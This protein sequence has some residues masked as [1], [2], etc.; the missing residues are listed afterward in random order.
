[1]YTHFL[2]KKSHQFC[3]EYSI[4]NISMICRFLCSQINR[5]FNF[6]IEELS[7]YLSIYIYLLSYCNFVVCTYLYNFVYFAVCKTNNDLLG[8][9]RT[10]TL[11]LF[12]H[13][14]NRLGRDNVQIKYIRFVLFR[15]IQLY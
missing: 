10:R 1:M 15:S 9:C 11:F 6:R 13:R 8:C 12:H 2:G 5:I 14:F 3:V 4:F 7:I